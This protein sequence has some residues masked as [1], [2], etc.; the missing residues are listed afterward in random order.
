MTQDLLSNKELLVA[1]LM[2]YY[3]V[4]PAGS[5]EEEGNAQRHLKSFER[6]EKMLEEEGRQVFG[7]TFP[8]GESDYLEIPFELCECEWDSEE[9]KGQAAYYVC[10]Q[11]ST[12]FDDATARKLR[13]FALR[14]YREV[15]G[16]EAHFVRAELYQKW[17]ISEREPFPIAG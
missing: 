15:C 12:K 8:S 4:G 9:F 11:S 16:D 3:T 14:A 13:D 1:E 2:L 7:V 10:V 5:A 17:A 6:L